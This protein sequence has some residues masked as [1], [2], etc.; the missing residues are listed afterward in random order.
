MKFVEWL[1]SLGM[2]EESIQKKKETQETRLSPAEQEKD[3]KEEK[4]AVVIEEE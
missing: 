4:A 2:I 3:E 1:K